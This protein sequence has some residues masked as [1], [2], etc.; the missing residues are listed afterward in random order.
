MLSISNCPFCGHQF[1]DEDRELIK[2][3]LDEKDENGEY[4]LGRF[5]ILCSG[6]NAEIM[7][8]R[9]SDYEWLEDE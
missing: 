4:K 2:M 8:K 9:Q 1:S 3:K 6:C 7:L 5:R